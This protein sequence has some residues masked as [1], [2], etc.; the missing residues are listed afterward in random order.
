MFIVRL[1]ATSHLQPL[2]TRNEFIHLNSNENHGN[3]SHETIN[4]FFMDSQ[5][6]IVKYIKCTKKL[7][8]NHPS[9][10][11]VSVRCEILLL[12]GNIQH[13][14]AKLSS[15]VSVK[16]VG[17][18]R[19]NAALRGWHDSYFRY[20]IMCKISTRLPLITLFLRNGAWLGAV[21]Q[22][23]ERRSSIFLEKNDTRYIPRDNDE[24]NEI[25]DCQRLGS[26]ST[27]IFFRYCIF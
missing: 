27:V 4:L 24:H 3:I 8:L 7:W 25:E 5:N 13:R 14:I 18:N 1:L 20:R 10:S 21:N 26:R 17:F 19:D 11:H 6:K 23:F 2:V 15:L 16:S 9:D 22:R 12:E